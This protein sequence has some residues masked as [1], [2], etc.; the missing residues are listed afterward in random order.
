MNM[1]F[2]AW[3]KKNG[4]TYNTALRLFKT[5]QLPV[6]A[7]QLKTGTFVVHEAAGGVICAGVI[8]RPEGEAERQ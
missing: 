1:K 2:C 4:L 3:A 6:F 7:R 5:D 8:P